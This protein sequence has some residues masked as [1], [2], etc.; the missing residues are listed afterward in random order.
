[1]TLPD[2]LKSFVDE[3]VAHRGYRDA[4]EFLSR[5]LRPSGGDKLVGKQRR[6]CKR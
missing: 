6:T 4:S 1:V 3:Q 5:F 2:A